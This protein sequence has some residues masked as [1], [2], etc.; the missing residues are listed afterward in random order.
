MYAN[1]AVPC[2]LVFDDG[3]RARYAHS[4]K[5]KPGKL[6]QELLDKGLLRT[7]PTIEELARKIDVDPAGLAQTISRFNENA[8]KGIDPDFGRG[9][10][11]YNDCLGD[12]GHTPNRALGALDTAPYYATEIFPADVGTCGGLVTDEYAQVLGEDD[13]PI[14]GLYATGNITATVMGRTYP[15]A[16]ASIANTMV[17]GYVA[18]RHAAGR[19]APDRTYR[20]ATSL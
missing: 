9:S 3:Y 19:L 17:F 20:G 10:S 12:P 11:A 2:W 16:G 13:R 15:G 8:R 14:P 4:A 1:K 7:A 18:A 5:P 6:P